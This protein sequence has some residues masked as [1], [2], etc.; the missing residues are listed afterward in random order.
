[1]IYDVLADFNAGD[2]KYN[3]DTTDPRVPVDSLSQFYNNKIKIE[4]TKIKDM[5]KALSEYSTLTDEVLGIEV[6]NED[7]YKRMKDLRMKYSIT[8]EIYPTDIKDLSNTAKLSQA[9]SKLKRYINSPEMKLIFDE[10]KKGNDYRAKAVEIMSMNEP[11]GILAMKDYLEKYGNKSEKSYTG[12]DLNINDYVPMDV[13][14]EISKL[15]ETIEKEYRLEKDPNSPTG[16]GY[17]FINKISGATENGKEVFN[18]RVNALKN[19]KR[20]DNNMKSYIAMNSAETDYNDPNAYDDFLTEMIETHLGDKIVSTDIKKIDAKVVLG[21]G[22]SGTG[23]SGSSSSSSYG[24]NDDSL[25]TE[26]ERNA[27]RTRMALEERED[28]KDY[29]FSSIEVMI[30][31]GTRLKEVRDEMAS[32]AGSFEKTPTGR[33][34]A[35]FT[36]KEGKDIE[37]PL[38]KVPQGQKRKTL[39]DMEMEA[40]MPTQQQLTPQQAAAQKEDVTINNPER[41]KAVSDLKLPSGKGGYT[42]NGQWAYRGESGKVVLVNDPVPLVEQGF[43]LKPNKPLTD[44][45]LTRSTANKARTFVDTIG[46]YTINE[47]GTDTMGRD[48]HKN[49]KHY[50]GTT[51]DMSLKGA[52]AN[53]PNRLFNTMIDAGNSGLMAQ[54]ESNDKDLVDKLNRKIANHNIRNQDNPLP[55]ALYGAK[56]KNHF[57]VYDEEPIKVVK[58]GQIPA[59]DMASEDRNTS[60]NDFVKANNLKNRSAEEVVE[61]NANYLKSN[62]KPVYDALSE[63]DDIPE[64]GKVQSAMSLISQSEGV[65]KYLKNN[66]GEVSDMIKFVQSPQIQELYMD[67]VIKSDYQPIIANNPSSKFSNDEKLILLHV[68]GTGDGQKVIKGQIPAMTGIEMLEKY[69]FIEDDEYVRDD[70]KA[71][72]IIANLEK[73]NSSGISQGI[74]SIFKLALKKI[75][76]EIAAKADPKE[77]IA[78]IETGNANGEYGKVNP[79]TPAIGKYQFMWNFHKDDIKK[80]LKGYEPTAEEVQNIDVPLPMQSDSV[81]GSNNNARFGLK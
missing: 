72:K 8:D 76:G 7:Q 24:L 49:K 60:Y 14:A 9:K 15:A 6:H 19:N 36:S 48:G 41:A 2:V 31:E 29:D 59:L 70:A 32:V 12:F 37:I 23:G 61:F 39:A 4:T 50:D 66:P 43:N 55:K 68:E 52:D 16:D 20:F 21:E 58:S 65:A 51:F 45:H 33:K 11:L 26:G 56:W 74:V 1:M 34:V 40:N 75:N 35:V 77:V 22:G 44:Y 78:A 42:Q 62:Y 47:A 53:D 54:F 3:K 63:N 27:R 13:D 38:N 46:D 81:V 80:L 73:Q 64:F 17:L 57:S 28:L 5:E 10:Q 30:P 69:G 71:N 67:N 79:R 18:R 25:K